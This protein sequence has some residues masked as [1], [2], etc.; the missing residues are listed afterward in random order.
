MFEDIEKEINLYINK[1]EK[2]VNEPVLKLFSKIYLKKDEVDNLICCIYSILPEEIKD[3]KRKDLNSSRI[4]K[5]LTS[6]FKK[7]K[8]N[9]KLYCANIDEIKN[10][11]KDYKQSFKEDIYNINT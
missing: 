10:T 9:K 6:I 5:N 7:T 8:M 3:L 2:I 11:I 4:L 1:L